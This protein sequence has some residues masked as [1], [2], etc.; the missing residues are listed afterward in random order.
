MSRAYVTRVVSVQRLSPSFLR[1][2]LAAEDL[3]HFY[4]GGLDQ[5]IK[6][7]L[8][9][10]DGGFPDLGFWQEPQPSIM[11]WYNDW[12]ALDDD[13]RNPIRTYT[14]RAIRPQEQQI[15]VDFVI[16]GTE[17]PASAWA[18]NAGVGDELIV[19]GPDGRQG[20]GGGIEWK[21]GTA[22]DVLL[23]GDETAVPAICAIL[24]SLSEEFTGDA[25]LEV[26]VAEDALEVETASSVRVHWL[27][28][29]GLPLGEKL[30]PAVREWGRHRAA[31]VAE[32]G[33]A[34]SEELAELDEE[35][36]LWEVSE[37][38][39]FRDYAWLAGEA[40]IIIPLRRHLVK[41]IGLSRHQVSFMG[42]WK[43][44]R[45]SS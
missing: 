23:A 10:E 40:G 18:L 38:E 16:H 14:V 26:P 33:A 11:Q 9:R 45:T 41:E 24:E 31:L 4:T 27:S 3:R 25:Y 15:D 42:Y 6:L 13:E 7:F 1:F 2:T 22:R 39:G 20:P 17:G 35:A 44:G 37:A 30:T 8:P 5:R 34:G 29:D 19:I 21:P 12:R 32:G 36:P 43:K 28:R